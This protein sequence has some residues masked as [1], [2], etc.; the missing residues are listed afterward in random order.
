MLLSTE[1]HPLCFKTIDDEHF[2]KSFTRIFSNLLITK[3]CF[4]IIKQKIKCWHIIF[5]MFVPFEVGR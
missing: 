5:S 3:K 4:Q 2:F 1:Y